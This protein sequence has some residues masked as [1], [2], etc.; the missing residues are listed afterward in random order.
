MN[1]VALANGGAYIGSPKDIEVA[2]AIIKAACDYYEIDKGE[3]MGQKC[4]SVSDIRHMCLYLIDSNTS[5]K[6]EKIGKIFNQSRFPVIYA[7]DKIDTHKRIYIRT[8]HALNDIV[9]L[10]NTFEKKYS[11]HIPRISTTH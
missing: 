4:T 8:L 3:L 5:L 1:N 6:R 2:N 11:W 9:N 10:A 7:V